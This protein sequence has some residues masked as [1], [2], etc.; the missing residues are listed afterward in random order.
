MVSNKVYVRGL[1]TY[2]H[3]IYMIRTAQFTEANNPLE[4]AVSSLIRDIVQK[5]TVN[6]IWERGKGTN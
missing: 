1:K 3:C 2:I 5:L 6:W 4:P